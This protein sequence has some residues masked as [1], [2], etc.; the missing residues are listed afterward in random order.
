MDEAQLE[1]F[2]MSELRSGDQQFISTSLNKFLELYHPK[3]PNK[4]SLPIDHI[5]KYV[6]ITKPSTNQL[7]KPI[8]EGITMKDA[9]YKHGIPKIIWTKE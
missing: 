1:N 4:T 9:E 8:V 5:V 6:D 3:S 7:K 2:A